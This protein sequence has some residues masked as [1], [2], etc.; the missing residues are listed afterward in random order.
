MFDLYFQ[1]F[2]DAPRWLSLLLLSIL[3]SVL[4]LAVFAVASSPTR[5]ERARQHLLAHLLEMRLFGEDPVLVLRAQWEL[6]KA[7][8]RYLFWMLVPIACAAVVLTPLFAQM[9]RYYAHQPLPLGEEALVTV[10]LQDPPDPHAPPPQL[11]APQGVQVE[12][13]AVRVAADS[14]VVWRVKADAPVSGTLRATFGWGIVEK[15]IVVGNA[16]GVVSP[17]RVHGFW[18]SWLYPGEPRLSGP[19]VAWAEV[20]YPSGRVPLFGMNLHWMVAFFLFSIP[21]ILILRRRFGVVF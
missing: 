9:D 10:Q 17:R 2:R 5:I 6:L 18:E 1:L 20:G 19:A 13:P 14:Q 21:V 16:Q 8:G 11:V 4:M 15:H 12:T 3:G 7:N